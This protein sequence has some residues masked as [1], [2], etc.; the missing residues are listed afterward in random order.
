VNEYQGFRYWLVETR[1]D[2]V[3]VWRIQFPGGHKTPPL[4]RTSEADVKADIDAII[5]GAAAP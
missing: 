3:K 4:E 2:G 5:A 1:T